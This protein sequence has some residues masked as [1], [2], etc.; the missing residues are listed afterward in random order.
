M[1]RIGLLKTH[2]RTYYSVGNRL[3]CE[4]VERK[5]EIWAAIR[6]AI[7]KMFN[8]MAPV[9]YDALAVTAESMGE[10][11]FAERLRKKGEQEREA[12]KRALGKE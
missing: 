7:K 6:P 3:I 4:N 12:I 11:K 9:E 2:D 5:A 8:K 1:E 10:S